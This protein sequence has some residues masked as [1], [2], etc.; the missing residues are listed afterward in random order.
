MITSMT[1]FGRGESSSGGYQVTV[2]VKTL[3]SRYLDISVRMPQ[4]IHDKE[5]DLKELVQQ[6]LSRGKVN[7]N[8]NVNRS[9]DSDPGIKLNEELVKSYSGI[10]KDLRSAAGI[11]EPVTVR[12]LL[13]FSDIFETK[14]EG[15]KEVQT[16]WNCTKAA[17]E[18]ALE[19]LNTMRQ[20]EGTELRDDL[21]N[22]VNGI[23]ELLENVIE[24]SDKR[25]PEVREKLRTRI[26]KMITEE[27]I[28]PE[29]MEMEIAL[30]VDKMD[31]NEEVIRLQSHLKFF[32]EALDADEPVGRRLNFLCQEINRELNTIG[33]KANDSTVAHHIVLGKEKL[34]QIR[35]QVQNIE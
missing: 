28:D 9:K 31:I 19:N 35:E 32:L 24:I 6:F 7:L 22:H 3:N 25:A 8:I 21:A 30:L 5:I 34:E 27:S 2:E 1:G 29:R 16:I 11:G 15:E 18:A 13:Q 14:K 20:K 23:I 33:S 26:Q 4:S 12:D 17:L 10:L